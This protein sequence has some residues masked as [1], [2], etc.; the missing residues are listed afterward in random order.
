MYTQQ[1]PSRSRRRALP[2]LAAVAASFLLVSCA[3][4]AA[5]D[6]GTPPVDAGTDPTFAPVAAAVD[7]VPEAL[8]ESGTLRVAMPT[9]EPP[10]Q[11]YREGTKEMTGIN[12]DMA[13]LVAGALDLELEIVVT[14]FDSIIPGL[15][16]DRFD[17]T[18]ASMSVTEERMETLDFVDYIQ[19]GSAI[20]TPSGNPEKIQLKDLCGERVGMLTGSYQL[21]ARIP[22]VVEECE[23]A[24]DKAPEILQFQDTRQAITAMLSGRSDVVYADLPI[25]SFAAKQNDKIEIAD[26]NTLSPVGMGI[27]RDTG[28]TE[29]VAAAMTAV[30]ASDEY[31]ALLDQYG[32]AQAAI[33]E[34]RVNAPAEG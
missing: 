22:A 32:M 8:R 21:T 11:Y 27:R 1:F 14:N 4:P 3:A 24:G 18:V 20:A 31:T 33:D 2:L 19:M 9:N 7:L 13:R 5:T 16:A 29:A 28:L 12:P 23:A 25:L 6:E 17:M 10:T 26:T 30:A 34:A 15:S